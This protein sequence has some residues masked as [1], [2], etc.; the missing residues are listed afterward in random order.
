[1]GGAGAGGV[2]GGGAAAGAWVR[3]ELRLRAAR[4]PV[5]RPGADIILGVLLTTVTR[6][7]SG[8]EEKVLRAFSAPSTFLANLGLITGEVRQC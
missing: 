5:R 4:T 8:A 1:M 2:A 7:V 6:Y 3:H